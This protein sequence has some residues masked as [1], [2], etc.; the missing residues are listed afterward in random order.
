MINKNHKG[1][2]PIINGNPCKKFIWAHAPSVVKYKIPK[3]ANKFKATG[4]SFIYKN[5]NYSGT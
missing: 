4:G 2:A 3:S 1:S 5:R